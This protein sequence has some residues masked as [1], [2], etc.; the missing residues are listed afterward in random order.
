[1]AIIPQA[2]PRDH[3]CLGGFSR[4]GDTLGKM[5]GGSFDSRLSLCRK[6]QAAEEW[7]KCVCVCV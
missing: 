3:L 1:M 5:V 4:A 7:L 6:G 2:F